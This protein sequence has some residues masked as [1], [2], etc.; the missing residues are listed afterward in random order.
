MPRDGVSL[1]VKGKSSLVFYIRGRKVIGRELCRS[2]THA[3]RK[4]AGPAGYEYARYE[5]ESP[6][7]GRVVLT[8]LRE[9]NKISYLIGSNLAHTSPK[10]ISDYKLRWSVEVFFRDSKQTLFLAEYHYQTRTA[11]FA[12]FVLRAITYHFADW[13]RRKKF[14][15][16][17]TIGECC[18]YLRRLLLDKIKGNTSDSKGQSLVEAFSSV[19]NG[20]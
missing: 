19:F 13:I 2:M 3:W 10:M 15:G 6:T 9:G 12:H 20:L 4:Y 17:R 11:I 14:Q 1:V 5:A 18:Q 8:V 7:L 16:R